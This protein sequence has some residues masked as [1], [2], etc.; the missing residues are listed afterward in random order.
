MPSAR[1]A[2]RSN[3]PASYT[4]SWWDSQLRRCTRR[5]LPAAGLVQDRRCR[6]VRMVERTPRRLASVTSEPEQRLSGRGGSVGRWPGRHVRHAGVGCDCRSRASFA[7]PPCSMSAPG[8]A[9]CVVRSALPARSRSP[10]TLSPDMLGEVGEAAVLAVAGDMCALPFT[11]RCFDAAVSGFAISHID[12]PERALDEMRR[13]IRPRRASDR[14]GVRGSRGSRVE[15]RHRRGRARVRVSTHRIGTS[16]SKTRTEPRSNTPGVAACL[17]RSRR[18]GR[19]RASPISRSDSGLATPEAI[20]AYRT[21]FGT[22]RAVR[23]VTPGLAPHGALPPRRC[24][25]A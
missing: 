6:R 21:R 9:R 5:R 15:G 13:V 19:H 3:P 20:I 11:D 22:P 16:S 14:D 10:W 2:R 23:G 25:R 12:A 1:I 17:R 24:R 8:P 18:P 7:A 4:E